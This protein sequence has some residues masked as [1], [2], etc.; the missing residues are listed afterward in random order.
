MV[1]AHQQWREI[2]FALGA[3][4][5]LGALAILLVIAANRHVAESGGRDLSPIWPV[6]LW[7]GIAGVGTIRCTKWGIVL[8]AGPTAGC[9]LY[10]LLGAA[11]HGYVVSMAMAV[12]FAPVFCAPAYFGVR[13]WRLLA[14]RW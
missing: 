14:T 11:T 6:A 12:A 4:A 8:F 7:L 9:W 3:L 1:R 2:F 10:W 5:L 13:Y